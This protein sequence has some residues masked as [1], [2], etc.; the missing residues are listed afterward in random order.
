MAER[1]RREVD[2]V[3]ILVNN[4]GTVSARK[5]LDLPDKHIERVFSIN[6]LAHFWVREKLQDLW[7]WPF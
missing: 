1:V 3:T 6:I 2:D 5:V 7:A 4:A